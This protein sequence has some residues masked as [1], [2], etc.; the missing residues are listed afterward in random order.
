[1]KYVKQENISGFSMDAEECF[2][3]FFFGGGCW[4]L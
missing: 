4:V 2:E 1:M 3:G